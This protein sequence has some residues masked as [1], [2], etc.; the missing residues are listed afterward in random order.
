MTESVVDGENSFLIKIET[1]L[2]NL[3]TSV[4]NILNRGDEMN[5]ITQEKLSAIQDQLETQAASMRKLRRSMQN[6]YIS[7][8][9]LCVIV[10]LLVIFALIVYSFTI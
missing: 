9:I 8:I 5:E 2:S 10:T 1:R 3:E 4:N 7:Y 6:P